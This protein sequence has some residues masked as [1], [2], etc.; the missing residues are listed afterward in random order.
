[1]AKFN[2]LREVNLCLID[3]VLSMNLIK[4]TMIVSVVQEEVL[5]VL[6][7]TLSS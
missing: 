4:T 7:F 3:V 5:W 2:E 1:M 6:E